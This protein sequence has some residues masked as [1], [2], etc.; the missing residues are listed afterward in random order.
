[1]ATFY[2]FCVENTWIFSV[3][4]FAAETLVGSGFHL[5]DLTMGNVP[6]L[7]HPLLNSLFH[8]AYLWVLTLG[9]SIFGR[10]AFRRFKDKYGGGQHFPEG[11]IE[12]G[13]LGGRSE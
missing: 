12:A 7:F 9:F 11:D 3:T 13:D 5:D 8:L 2:D 10:F 1:M 4:L 6:E